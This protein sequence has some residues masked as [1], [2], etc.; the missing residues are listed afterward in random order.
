MG[1]A[2]TGTGDTGIS[3]PRPRPD[4]PEVLAAD[5]ETAP[6]AAL[7][8]PAALAALAT[9]VPEGAAPLADVPPAAAG[10]AA[11]GA[12][13]AALPSAAAG[14]EAPLAAPEVGAS[15][16][17]RAA[18]EGGPVAAALA[19]ADK[20]MKTPSLDAREFF[21]YLYPLDAIHGGLDHSRNVQALLRRLQ[22]L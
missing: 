4:L 2:P 9:E 19:D 13:S 1:Q 18:S 7:A 10:R 14:A 8:P 6:V 17:G 3:L 16:A 22:L 12:A 15:E 11:L 20:Q 21:L 5:L